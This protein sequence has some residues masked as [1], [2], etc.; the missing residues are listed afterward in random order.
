MSHVEAI[1][2]DHYISL[3][4]LMTYINAL[5][6]LNNMDI[7]S[8]QSNILQPLYIYEAKL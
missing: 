8:V 4:F 2:F 1:K 7:S 3:W 6:T 5:T